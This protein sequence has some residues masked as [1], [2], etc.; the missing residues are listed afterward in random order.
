MCVESLRVEIAD[1]NA[2]LKGWSGRFYYLELLAVESV[3]KC[4]SN[5]LGSS[6]NCGHVSL[7][8]EFIFKLVSNQDDEIVNTSFSGEETSVPINFN[9]SSESFDW[10]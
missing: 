4:V 2:F 6:E 1:K 8:I 5:I 7:G 10:T 9:S 3:D